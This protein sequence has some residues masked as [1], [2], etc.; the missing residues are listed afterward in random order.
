VT[1]R[2]IDL[3]GFNEYVN[4]NITAMP[5]VF[6]MTAWVNNDTPASSSN[7]FPVADKNPEWRIVGEDGTGEPW[8][9]G[10]G[11]EA[12]LEDGSGRKGA[13]WAYGGQDQWFFIAAVF[14]ANEIRLYSNGQLRDTAAMNG[15]IPNG[16]ALLFG[17]KADGDEFFNGGIDE[18]R[19]YDRALADYEIEAIR[20]HDLP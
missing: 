2:A 14:D 8:L 20:Q 18:L 17:K 16:T 10:V 6:T 7:K 19:I 12:S 13:G 11:V 4:T 9:S 3:N 1:G 5:T 15:R